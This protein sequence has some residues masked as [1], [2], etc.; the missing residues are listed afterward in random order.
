MNIPLKIRPWLLDNPHFD[1]TPDAKWYKTN[2]PSYAKPGD[3]GMDIRA[4][5]EE[6]ETLA[7]GQTVSIPTGLA[8]HIGQRPELP[9]FYQVVGLILP[10]SGLGMLNGI[11][12]GNGT[13]V[14][15]QDYQGEIIVSIYNRSEHSYL[16]QPAQK[17]CQILF[18][19]VLD[20]NFFRVQN[21]EETTERGANGFGS[22]GQ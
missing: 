14:I 17:I 19:P 3:A 4:C 7:P 2:G 15:D 1:D 21:F 9:S 6:P 12:L 8:I 18:M 22:T 10:R 13:G 11:I 16:I 5:I 20:V